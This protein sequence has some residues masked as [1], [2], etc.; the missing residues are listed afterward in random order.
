MKKALLYFVIFLALYLGACALFFSGLILYAYMAGVPSDPLLDAPWVEDVGLF[1]AFAGILAYFIRRP[2]V[3]RMLTVRTGNM[4][5]TCALAAV[6]ALCL[7]FIESPIIN[8]LGLEDV[9]K[10]TQDSMTNSALSLLTGCAFAPFVEEMVFRGAITSSL[11]AWR[12]NVV[13]ALAV[14]SLLFAVAHLYFALTPF[15]F[16]FGLIAGW[17]VIRTGSL[18]PSVVFH[19]TNNI[20]CAATD[21]INA[22]IPKMDES[23][24]TALSWAFAAA[25]AIGLTACIIML[26]RKTKATK[27]VYYK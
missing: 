19:A 13:V 27:S 9:D 23:T 12:R 18:W 5:T 3:R 7:V 10:D 22:C 17:F 24:E 1:L 15:Y 2:E 4:G 6:A 20:L 14:P 8:A 21:Y 25:G 26:N 16:A 11:L